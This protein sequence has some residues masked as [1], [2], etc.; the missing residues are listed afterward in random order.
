MRYALVVAFVAC[1]LTLHSPGTVNQRHDFNRDASPSM[2]RCGPARLLHCAVLALFAVQP[3]LPC[4]GARHGVARPVRSFADMR[5]TVLRCG[6]ACTSC[7]VVRRMRLTLT[8]LRPLPPR[9]FAILASLPDRPKLPCLGVRNNLAHPVA[10]CSRRDTI[11]VVKTCTARCTR[12]ALQSRV[13]RRSVC[14]ACCGCRAV[15]GCA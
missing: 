11:K 4:V 9:R 13:A 5:L 8:D 10:I 6:P 2:V 12:K 7:A 15:A 14:R 1:E 3:T